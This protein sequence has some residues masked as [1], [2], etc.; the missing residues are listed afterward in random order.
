MAFG[1]IRA[2]PGV[3]VVAATSK[4]PLLGGNNSSI[5]AERQP[6]PRNQNEGPLVE[7][8][9]ITPEYFRTMRIPLLKGR[10]FHRR[11]QLE[12]VESGPH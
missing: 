6:A 4:L 1:K 10:F 8:S 3:E 9:I 2:L 12:V 11:R 7:I 5:W